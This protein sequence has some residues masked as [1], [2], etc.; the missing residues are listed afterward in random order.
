MK[1]KRNVS[2]LEARKIAG[3]YMGEISYA[4]VARRADTTNEVNKY[5]TLVEKLIQLDAKDWPNFQ[6]HLKNYTRPNFTKYQ[7]S[8][9]LGMGRDPMLWFKQKHT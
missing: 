8:N 9:K 3:S 5:R 4:F 6:E 2:F 1:H 7:L